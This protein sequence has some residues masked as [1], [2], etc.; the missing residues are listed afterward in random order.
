MLFLCIIPS[1]AYAHPAD[2]P[3]PAGLFSQD[4]CQPRTLATHLDND[5]FNAAHQAYWHCRR[6]LETDGLIELGKCVGALQAEGAL[7]GL[8][9]LPT[10]EE[11]SLLSYMDIVPAMPDM[12]LVDSPDISRN[13]AQADAHTEACEITRGITAAV[14]LQCEQKKSWIEAQL[15]KKLRRR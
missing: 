4:G 1:V 10:T 2:H 15:K 8:N 9:L 3:C 13:V 11:E 12:D 14:I 5:E 7:L 6:H